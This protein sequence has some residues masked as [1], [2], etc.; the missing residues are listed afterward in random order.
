MFEST[1]DFVQLRLGLGFEA[2]DDAKSSFTLVITPNELGS[3]SI[4][5]TL[6]TFANE[7]AQVFD[8]DDSLESIVSRLNQSLN[9]IAT[10][11]SVEATK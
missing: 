7:N 6:V 4:T 2:I 1:S 3:T 8:T 5:D 9:E 11:S 10:L